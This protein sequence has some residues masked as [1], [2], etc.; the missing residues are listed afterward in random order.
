MADL[1]LEITTPYKI[2]YKGDI[3]SVTIPGTLGSFQILKNHAPLISTFEIGLIKISEKNSSGKSGKIFST[4][5]GTVEVLNNKV[6][7]LADSLEA[8]SDI[9]VERARKARERA[10]NRLANKTNTTDVERAKAALARA[11]NRLNV[12]ERYQT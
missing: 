11:L 4:G 12:V 7:V 3:E 10:K 2:V 5:G 8:A 1:N 9:D 6:T